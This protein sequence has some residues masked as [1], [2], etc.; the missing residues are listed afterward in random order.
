VVWDGAVTGDEAEDHVRGLL[1]DPDWPPGPKHL[2]DTTTTTAIPNIANTKLVELLVQATTMHHIRFAI[3]ADIH[4]VEASRFQR[5]AKVSGV[6]E[7]L[8]FNDLT[9]ACTWVRADL[10]AVRTILGDLRHRLRAH[11][12]GANA[13]DPI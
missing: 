9:T 4:F 7:V 11:P 1:A 5:A 12:H 13:D 10:A 3:I 6:S 2:V 8:V